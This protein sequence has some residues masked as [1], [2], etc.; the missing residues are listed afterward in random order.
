MAKISVPH[1]QC[2]NCGADRGIATG[3]GTLYGSPMQTCPNCGKVY[4][5]PRYREI[6]V[7]GLLDS[8]SKGKPDSKTALIAFIV[9]IAAFALTI[10]L[11][12]T[13]GRLVFIFPIVG[14]LAIAL[15]FKTT[16]D[17]SKIR[18]G[19]RAAELEKLRAESEARLQ[20]PS[21]ARLLQARGYAVP[22][23]YLPEAQPERPRT[24]QE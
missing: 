23:Q 15:G 7:D 17:N 3:N 2:P 11:V 20:D 21:Y 4:F 24:P 22:A 12:A 5:D 19:E 8:D 16:G 14:V 13:T 18:S 10:L 1:M 9:G 6:A